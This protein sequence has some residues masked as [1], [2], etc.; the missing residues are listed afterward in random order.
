M[1]NLEENKIFAKERQC[2]SKEVNNLKS[3]V[4]LLTHCLKTIKKT[5]FGGRNRVKKSQTFLLWYL[6]GVL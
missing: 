1:N 5:P 3:K 6:D 4:A 2:I